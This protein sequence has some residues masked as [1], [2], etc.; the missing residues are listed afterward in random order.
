[1]RNAYSISFEKSEY[2]RLLGRC[3]WR[4]YINIRV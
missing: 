3:R 2:K 4:W 1:M